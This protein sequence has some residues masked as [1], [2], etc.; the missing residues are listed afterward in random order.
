MMNKPEQPH[1]P[2]IMRLI[3]DLA[4]AQHVATGHIDTFELKKSV[5]RRVWNIELRDDLALNMLPKKL[6]RALDAHREIAFQ[7]ALGQFS[8]RAPRKGIEA[9]APAAFCAALVEISIL[10]Q[11][12]QTL[13]VALR[14]AFLTRPQALRRVRVRR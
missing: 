9:A 12:G 3:G 10:E 4:V 5:L 7:N 11:T 13:I 14:C 2:D 8:R 1:A 6:N